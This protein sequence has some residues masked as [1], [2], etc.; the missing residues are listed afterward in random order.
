VLATP[1][2]V[3]IWANVAAAASRQ[4]RPFGVASGSAILYFGANELGKYLDGVAAAGISIVRTD[5]S[6]PVVQPAGPN[7]YDWSALDR[8]VNAAAARSLGVVGILDYTPAWARPSGTMQFDP[9]S[10]PAT[11]ARF[12][13]AAAARYRGRVA[14]YEV[15]NEPNQSYFWRP[16]P[17][18]A[19]YAALLRAAYPAIKA[20]DS[21]ALVLG[22]ATTGGWSGTS[23]SKLD[24]VVFLERVYA[25]GG[26]GYFDA[27]SHH[28][29][30][31]DLGYSPS[32]AWSKMVDTSPSIRSTMAAHGDAAKQL[33]A[34]EF[35][36]STTDVGGSAQA[37]L[38]KDAVAK[39]L[40][41]SWGGPLCWYSYRD[42]GKKR[43]DSEQN[44]VLVR[45]DWSAKP[46][47]QAYRSAITGR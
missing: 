39:W 4:Q 7:Q 12:C 42:T 46:A 16:E 34:T 6:W 28:P 37:R 14:T 19:A 36:A 47:L 38:A 15:W 41:Y 10:D 44:F 11:F 33:W 13:A 35:G 3:P 32:S 5:F 20:A 40:T 27:W 17:N 30:T 18:P 31:F 24:P 29:Y 1:V 21:S 26:G 2:I 25:A 45:Y 43:S 23:G 8:I 22:G 9:P